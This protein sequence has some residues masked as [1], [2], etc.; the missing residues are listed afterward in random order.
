[1]DLKEIW[2]RLKGI[3]IFGIAYMATFFFIEARHVPIHIIHTSFDD[4]IPFCEY[5]VIPYVMWYFYVAATILYLALTYK[6]LKEYNRFILNMELGMI[7]FVIISF[8]YPNGQNLRPAIEVDGFCTW[9]IHLLYTIDTSTNILPS[10]HVFASVACAMALCRDQRVKK[11]PLY[12]WLICLL[13]LSICLSTMFIKQH[14]I[15]DVTL[16][17]LFNV[18]FYPVVYAPDYPRA[19]AASRKKPVRRPLT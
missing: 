18:L 8:A 7:V 12:Q 3:I 15:I 13:T 5:F 16:A 19:R 11:K 2:S 14:S 17:L 6:D 1:M 10:L 9:L 4:M